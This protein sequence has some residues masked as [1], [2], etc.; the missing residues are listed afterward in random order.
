MFLVPQSDAEFSALLRFLAGSE[1]RVL[2]RGSNVLVSDDGIS[3]PVIYTGG[4]KKITADKDTIVA[5][6]GAM[7]RDAAL[8]A[9][10]CSLTGLEFA[11]GIPGSVG[12]AVYMNAGAY[13]GEISQVL[14][15]SLV[16]MPDGTLRELSVE[17]HGF[18]YRRSSLMENGAVLLRAEFKLEKGDRQAIEERMKDLMQRRRDKQPLEYPSAGSTFKRPEG[19]YAGALIEQCGLKGASVGGAQ[20]SEKH[21]GFVINRGGASFDDVIGLVEKIKNTVFEQTGVEL[22]EEIRIWRD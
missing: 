18:S 12:G 21:A 6:C 7:L 5:E 16:C 14:S 11:H 22:E 4:M 10:D 1:F 20:V 2:G 19:H 3:C 9:R 15:S 8:R 13:G 17:D